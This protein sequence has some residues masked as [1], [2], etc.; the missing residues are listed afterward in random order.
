MRIYPDKFRLEQQFTF[1]QLYLNPGKH[2]ENLARDTAQLLAKLNQ[3]DGDAGFAGWETHSC[4]IIASL[5]CRPVKLQNSSP[6]NLPRGYVN[7]S[8][9]IGKARSRQF[10]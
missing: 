1:H 4:W 6:K 2:G 5:R 7:F 8:P 10:R 9:A 3:A